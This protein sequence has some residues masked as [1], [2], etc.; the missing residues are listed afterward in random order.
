MNINNLSGVART[1]YLINNYKEIEAF[2][3]REIERAR[4]MKAGKE[5]AR[6]IIDPGTNKWVFM[7]Y[8]RPFSMV[9]NL[10]QFDAATG[11]MTVEGRDKWQRDMSRKSFQFEK[12]GY[13]TKTTHVPEGWIWGNPIEVNF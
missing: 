6:Y 1:D 13:K 4:T 11:I 2:L 7:R 10:V 12:V 9:N 3:D 5:D 8:F